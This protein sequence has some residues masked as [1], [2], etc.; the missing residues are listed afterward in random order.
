MGPTRLFGDGGRVKMM[1]GAGFGLSSPLVMSP[2][3]FYSH[4]TAPPSTDLCAELQ[5][6]G[7]PED[8]VGWAYVLEGEL[9]AAGD[10]VAKEKDLMI[11][12]KGKG[13]AG[14][15]S[16]GAG[17]SE[18]IF[19]FGKPIDEPWVKLLGGNGFVIAPTKD[20]AEALMAKYMADKTA[21]ND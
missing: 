18:I 13:L 12:S 14:L 21:F 5:E 19:G 9:T 1:I 17:K 3:L 6:D 20:D 15:R 7:V 10:R 11:F 8:Y 16:G 4:V 2:T